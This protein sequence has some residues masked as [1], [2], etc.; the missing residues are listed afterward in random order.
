MSAEVKV[1]RPIRK[2][3]YDDEYKE[4]KEYEAPK[5]IRIMGVPNSNSTGFQLGACGC[6]AI[7]RDGFI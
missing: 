5:G 3:F 1:D 4:C 6:R 7:L 2:V